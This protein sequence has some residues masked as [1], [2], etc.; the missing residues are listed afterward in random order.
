MPTSL[1]EIPQRW[2]DLFALIPGY[3]PVAT[4]RGCWFDVAKAD[5]AVAFFPAMLTHVEGELAGRPFT[6]APWQAAHVGCAFGWKRPDGTRRYREV[7][8]YEPRKNGKTAKLAGLMNYVSLCDNESGAQNYSAAAE[9]EQAALLYRVAKLQLAANPQLEKLVKFYATFKSIEYREGVTY[10]ALSADADT[11]HGF[12]SHF[13]AVDELHAQPN[14]HLV[15]VLVTSTGARRQPMVWYITTAD[16]LRE[17]ICNEKYDYACKVRDGI[18]EDPAFLPIIYEATREEDWKSPEVWAKANPNLGVSVSPEYLERE[19]KRAQDIPAYENTFRRLHLNQQTET[20]TRA[21]PMDRWADCGKVP[22]PSLDGRP[23]F[24][25]LDLSTT[26]D[27]SAFVLLFPEADGGYSVLP[28]FWAP[29]EGARKRETRD[30]VPYKLWERQG[31]LKLTDGDVI[32]YDVIRADINALKLRYNI[33]KIAADRWNATQIVTQLMGDG[34]EVAAYGQGFK[35]MTAPTKELLK[36]VV[37]GKLY[38][39]NNAILRWMAAN[40]AT[41]TD[42]AG[43]LKPSKKKSSERIDGMVALVMA[44]GLALVEPD[45]K[46]VYEKRGVLV[47]EEPRRQPDRAAWDDDDW[48]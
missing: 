33:R 44:L 9:R 5:K 30:R 6:L 18:I 42:A 19:C 28:Q 23:C 46:S 48:T 8:D 38:H 10:K 11:K 14:R 4:A 25:G 40:L 32:D 16:F 7:F 26:T 24:A 34:F 13:I 35:D 41:E 47:L 43:N 27:L 2:L 45:G 12:N 1:A 22:L 21:V 36:L 3:D 39:G 37:A 15:D 20:D 29:A 31:L 17:S